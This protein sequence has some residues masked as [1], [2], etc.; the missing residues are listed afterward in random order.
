MVPGALTARTEGDTRTT[1][2]NLI[3][4]DR[5]TGT[6]WSTFRD[7]ETSAA[8]WPAPPG[9]VADVPRPGSPPGVIGMHWH[10]EGPASDRH[11]HE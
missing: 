4:V 11:S 3:E 6:R 5:D 1:S 7:E 10:V 2:V 8:E 9:S